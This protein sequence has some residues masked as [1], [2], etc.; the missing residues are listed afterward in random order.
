[1]RRLGGASAALFAATFALHCGGREGTLRSVAAPATSGSGSSSSGPAAASD[2]LCGEGWKWDGT[3]CTQTDLLAVGAEGKAEGRAPAKGGGGPGGG[4]P[5]GRGAGGDGPGGGGPGGSGEDG[6][7]GGGGSADEPS[8]ATS[9]QS[10][11]AAQLVVRDV[12]LG[13]GAEAKAGDNVRIHYVGTLADG[14]EFDSSR[15][16]GIPF[17]F[18]LGSGQVIKGF[19]RGVVGMKVGGKRQLTIPPE[20]GYGRKGAPPLI[21]PRAT[22]VFEIELL[23]VT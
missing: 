7:R 2:P 6:A 21:P 23:D 3:R 17:E 15:K 11:V 14:T 22:L 1:M 4:G 5:G 19:D 9:A 10:G 20:L 8:R 18:R 12:T 16:R 13:T